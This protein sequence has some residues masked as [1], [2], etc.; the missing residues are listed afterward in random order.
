VD[1]TLE[2]HVHSPA[3]DKECAVY[4]K[5]IGKGPPSDDSDFDYSSD[6][7]SLWEKDSS[8][9][10]VSSVESSRYDVSK[11]EAEFPGANLY[12]KTTTTRF[13]SS[14]CLILSYL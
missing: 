3:F 10:S 14:F 6:H 13:L 4:S 2:L 7:S 11:L 5:W 8:S 1:D 12:S 9:S